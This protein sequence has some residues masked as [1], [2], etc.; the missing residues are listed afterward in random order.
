LQIECQNQ[1]ACLKNLVLTPAPGPVLHHKYKRRPAIT[2]AK[3]CSDQNRFHSA[4]LD[5]LQAGASNFCA[6]QLKRAAL[7]R[8]QRKRIAMS[9]DSVKQSPPIKDLERAL[10]QWTRRGNEH[11]LEL[12]FRRELNSF[13]IPKRVPLSLWS[14]CLAKILNSARAGNV[15][16][17]SWEDPITRLFLATSWF[18]RKDGRA[19]TLFPTSRPEPPFDGIAAGGN[20]DAANEAAR[21]VRKL[22]AS[23][24]ESRSWTRLR[25]PVESET[26]F[27][28]LRPG[29]PNDDFLAIDHRAAAA[30]AKIE[31]HGAGTSWL[32]PLWKLSG[33]L[34][35][36]ST[37]KPQTWF[38]NSAGSLA[39]WTFRAGKARVTHSALIL[40]NRSLAFLSV[41][42]EYP[43]PVDTSSGMEL[44]LA[45]DIVAAAAENVRAFT[46]KSA[47]K[48]KSAQVLPIGLPSLPYATDKGSLAINEGSLVLKQSPAGRRCWLPLLVSWD[49][50]RGRK[51]LH[52][53]IL[54][55]SEQSKNVSPDTAFAVRVSWG[56]D[57]T[58]LIY[59]SFAP[60]AARAFLGHQS[61]ARFF[62][63]AFNRDGGVE[64][65]FRLD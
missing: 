20:S 5:Q 63:G 13:G 40:G 2:S 24:N 62:V 60:P 16:P 53:R 14:S 33:D 21:F 23:T 11:S 48:G 64:P 9:E 41:L 7:V 44:V 43:A 58:Y 36:T 61:T 31:L 12:W 52:W 59:R 35:P 57:E 15:W 30:P 32:G 28:V 3:K 1:I 65:I 19:V 4:G 46:L 51:N 17:A 27:A 37:P 39:E 34:G 38:S 55:V 10:E 56:R 25:N 29:W 42:I 26:P 22:T 54:S 18:S 45:P 47:R 49:G 8:T 50:Q 6:R